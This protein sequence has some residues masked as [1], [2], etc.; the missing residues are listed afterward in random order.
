MATPDPV[1]RCPECETHVRRS[2]VS[3]AGLCP[4]CS[5]WAAHQGG[6]P[7]RLSALPAWLD[8][9]SRLLGGGR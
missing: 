5:R 4:P 7:V 6:L 1:V 3:G 2:V 9:L 8:R